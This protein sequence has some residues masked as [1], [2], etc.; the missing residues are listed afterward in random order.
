MFEG[1]DIRENRGGFTC[2]GGV[3]ETHEY[4][5]KQRRLCMFGVVEIREYQGEQRRLYM[6]RVW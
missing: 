4:Q 6:F 5:G 3:V 2:F 1:V